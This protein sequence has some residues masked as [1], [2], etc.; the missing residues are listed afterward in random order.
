MSRYWP[1]AIP[2]LLS[3]CSSSS[4]E[5]VDRP[6]AGRLISRIQPDP[7]GDIVIAEHYTGGGGGDTT[8]RLL[9][10]QQKTSRCDVLGGIDTHGGTAPTLLVDPDVTLLVNRGDTIWD[11]SNVTN[12]LQSGTTRIIAL[13]YR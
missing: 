2:I 9:A 3:G 10:C 8:Y 13:K 1:V 12:Y 6:A 11:F 5:V 7:V 4:V